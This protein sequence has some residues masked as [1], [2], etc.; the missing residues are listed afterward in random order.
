MEWAEEES[1][2]P[3]VEWD[4]LLEQEEEDGVMF[5]YRSSKLSPLGTAEEF[6]QPTPEPPLN[7]TTGIAHYRKTVP[8]VYYQPL[9]LT[10]EPHF[11]NIPVDV[12]FST[13]HVPTNVFDRGTNYIIKNVDIILCVDVRP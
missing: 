9:D 11:F 7:Y 5:A 6:P 13:V 4:D 12:N 10:P 2:V 1:F 8:P 3:P